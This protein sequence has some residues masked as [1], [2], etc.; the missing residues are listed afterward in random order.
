M[1]GPK[2]LLNENH[3][4]SF[5]EYAKGFGVGTAQKDSVSALERKHLWNVGHFERK[6]KPRVACRKLSAQFV[7]W[8]S[9]VFT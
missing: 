3:Q 9:D 1:C 4:E 2:F 8:V 6:R 7:S 5:R